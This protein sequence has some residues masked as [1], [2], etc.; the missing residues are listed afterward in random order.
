MKRARKQARGDVGG[1]RA[2]QEGAR[3]RPSRERR[4]GSWTKTVHLV[5]TLTQKLEPLQCPQQRRDT[6]WSTL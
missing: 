2:P 4:K 3:P 5:R 1:R 6:L